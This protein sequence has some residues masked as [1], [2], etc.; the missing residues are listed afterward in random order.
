M[1]KLNITKEQ[2]EKL[3]DLDLDSILKKVEERTKIP[4]FSCRICFDKKRVH[5]CGGSDRACPS[6]GPRY[7]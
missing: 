2:L 6:C 5:V 3:K 1:D 4:Y 7:K